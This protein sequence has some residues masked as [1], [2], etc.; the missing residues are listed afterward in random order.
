MRF[1]SRFI[2]MKRLPWKVKACLS[3]GIV[4]ASWMTRPAIVVASSSGRFQSIARLRSRIGTV[5]VDDDRAVGL[6]PDALHGDVVLVGDVADDLLDDVLERHQA[7]HLAIFV[8]DDGEMRLAPQE[9]VELVLQRGGVGHEPRL[10]RDLQ[11]CRCLPESLPAA[12]QRAQ[13]GPWR[14]ARR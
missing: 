9:G 6:L 1:F 3:S 13:A 2:T 8:D 4:C 5:A 14:A 11:R 10:R 7:L 12:C